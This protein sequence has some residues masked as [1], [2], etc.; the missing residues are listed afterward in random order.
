MRDAEKE[1][2]DGSVPSPLQPN[3]ICLNADATSSTFAS[4][5]AGHSVFTGSHLFNCL[6]HRGNFEGSEFSNC[7]FDGTLFDNCSLAGVQLRN[8][9]VDGLVI[10]GVRI[11]E[12]LRL[13]VKGGV[14]S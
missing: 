13:I 8:C 5:K 14:L 6:H 11:G 4:L 3:M 12:L 9:D 7:E 2:D 10:N 1:D